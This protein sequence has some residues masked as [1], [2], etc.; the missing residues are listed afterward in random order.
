MY[1]DFGVHT[2]CALH[3]ALG[4]F[5]GT[6]DWGRPQDLLPSEYLLS[7][8]PQ[9]SGWSHSQPPR[10]GTLHSTVKAIK[11]TVDELKA[12][13]T[14]AHGLPDRENRLKGGWQG[15]CQEVLKPLGGVGRQ[16]LL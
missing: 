14:P 16:R 15:W 5:H 10:N 13:W 4:R 1:T 11:G 8:R 3:D 9:D 7:S 2:A 12:G 6:E